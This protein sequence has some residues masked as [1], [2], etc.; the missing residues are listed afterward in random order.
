MIL[1]DSK[2]LNVFRTINYD[3]QSLPVA[4]RFRPLIN[5]KFSLKKFYSIKFHRIQTSSL[6]WR[7]SIGCYWGSIE[8]SKHHLLNDLA[9]Q[10][11]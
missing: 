7:L 8:F 10:M 11:Q 3:P 4:G 2:W 5:E 9:I 6:E 1:N